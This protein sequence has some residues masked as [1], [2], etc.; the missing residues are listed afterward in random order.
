MLLE[1]RRGVVQKIAPLASVMLKVIVP[2]EIGIGQLISTA[3]SA[4]VMAW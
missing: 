3:S 2:S 4:D 1:I